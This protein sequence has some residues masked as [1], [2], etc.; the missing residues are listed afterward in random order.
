[1]GPQAVSEAVGVAKVVAD[2]GLVHSFGEQC[3]DVEFDVSGLGE[4]QNLALDVGQ[5]GPRQIVKVDVS[6]VSAG[7]FHRIPTSTSRYSK[8]GSRGCG[9]FVKRHRLGPGSVGRR[10]YEG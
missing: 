4:L 7:R 10:D 2:P 9:R 6:D 8:D 1:M 3:R 5:H